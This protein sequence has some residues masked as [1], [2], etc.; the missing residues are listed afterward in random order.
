MEGLKNDL[1]TKQRELKEAR[2]SGIKEG[3]S[4]E[5]LPSGSDQ[6]MTQLKSITNDEAVL[7]WFGELGEV[8]ARSEEAGRLLEEY[9]GEKER[10]RKAE[11][12][13]VKYERNM[14]KKLVQL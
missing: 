1:A 12:N 11:D 8:G 5:G 10:R 9:E 2:V 13:L 3:G 14:Q 7:K 4:M 6:L